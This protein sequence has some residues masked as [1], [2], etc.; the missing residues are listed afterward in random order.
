MFCHLRILGLPSPIG[1]YFLDIIT[2]HQYTSLI[3]V[4]IHICA[5]CS[6]LHKGCLRSTIQPFSSALEPASP[7]K[8]SVEA[9]D[10]YPR[11]L[12][13]SFNLITIDWPNPLS[14]ELT[15]PNPDLFID[16][17]AWPLFIDDILDHSD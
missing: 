12:R 17:G 15:D 14:R 13:P 6:V 1:A 16:E 7:I 2:S 5:P 4:G 9:L 8:A 10:L 11:T 3:A